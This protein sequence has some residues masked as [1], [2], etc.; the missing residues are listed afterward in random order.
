MT[1]FN[2]D[3]LYLTKIRLVT[4]KKINKNGKTEILSQPF[5]LAIVKK[6]HINN[7]FDK[8]IYKNVLN[9]EVYFPAIDSVMTNCLIYDE[10][11]FI[12][13]KNVIDET[14]VSTRTIEKFIYSLYKKDKEFVDN[15]FKVNKDCEEKIA[16]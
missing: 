14:I 1:K 2:I 9:K 6:D 13:L 15:L 16:M 5:G 11:N 12:P 3:D 4:N 8:V 10:N 7:Y